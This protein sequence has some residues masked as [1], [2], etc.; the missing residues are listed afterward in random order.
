MAFLQPRADS[1]NEYIQA[2]N[3]GIRRTIE[4]ANDYFAQVKQTSDATID[5]RLLVN[6]ADLSYKKAVYLA[7]SDGSAGIDVDEFISKCIAYM[8]EGPQDSPTLATSSQHRRPRAAGRSQVD[9]DDSDEDQGD[10]LNWERLGRAAVRYN[11]RPAVSGFLLGPLS[12]QKRA[13]QQTQRRARERIDPSQVVQPQ[14]LRNED[15]DRQET[16]NLTAVCTSINKLL[17]R[18]QV[19]G[20]NLVDQELSSLPAEKV[21]DEIRREVTKK[22]NLADNGGVC[23]FRFCVNPRS[24]GQTVENLFYLSFLIRDSTV[25]VNTDSQG[26]LT[27][28]G[29]PC[30]P[31]VRIFKLTIVDRFCRTDG[32]GRR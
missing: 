15:L 8:R 23:L 6:A 12:V 32:T 18:T 30:F 22:H 21:T 7:Q 4:K 3:D 16:S 31:S 29:C 24:F 10:S 28:R 25:G 17:A 27:I 26:Y 13:R 20:R 2:G 5:S 19:Q 11:A 1:R 9:P 14:D